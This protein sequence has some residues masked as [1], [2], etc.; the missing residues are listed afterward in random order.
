[1]LKRPILP[2]QNRPSVQPVYGLIGGVYQ[3]KSE[4]WCNVEHET[5]H[6]LDIQFHFCTADA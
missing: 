6:R 2:L 3:T 5:F 4:V 1:M